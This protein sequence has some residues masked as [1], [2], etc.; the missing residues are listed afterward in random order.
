MIAVL[1]YSVNA[2]PYYG[3]MNEYTGLE[4]NTVALYNFNEDQISAGDFVIAK[5]LVSES[6]WPEGAVLSTDMG[7]TAKFDAGGKF[8]W[9]LFTTNYGDPIIRSDYAYISKPPFPSGSNPS[10]SVE[11]WIM[12]NRLDILQQYIIDYQYTNPSGYAFVLT[13]LPE[14]ASDYADLAFSVG[15]GTAKIYAF[16]GTTWQ[17]NTWYHIAGTWDA[18]TQT[19]HLYRNGIEIGSDVKPGAMIV[20]DTSPILHI[21]ERL[22]SSY[23]GLDGAIDGFRVSDKAYQYAVPPVPDYCGAPGTVYT[24]GDLNGDCYVDFRDFAEL[25]EDWLICTDPENAACDENWK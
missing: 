8:G 10:I 11:F 23:N 5:E 3:W 9:G 1:A 21:G 7:A 16:A 6:Y 25:A 15:D 22:A 20:N 18:A 13:H 2:E 4:P 14:Y 19:I 24:K 17:T 12:F